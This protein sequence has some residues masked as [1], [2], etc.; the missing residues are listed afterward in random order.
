MDISFAVRLPVDS[1]SVPFVRGLCRQ[2]LEHLSVDT[3]VI[4]DV[5]LALTEACAN[6]V[7][8]AGP[9]EEYEVHVD[10]SGNLCRI[11][12]VDQGEGFDPTA[13]QVTPPGSVLERGRGMMLMQALVDRLHFEHDGEGRHKVIL[14][15]HL[16]DTP[17]P[18]R[19][20]T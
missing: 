11:S 9:H 2:A 14:E 15:K 19:L 18:L 13:V 3:P 12:V 5:V 6:V 20:L 16:F 4:E 8:H 10:I 17:P 1:K 7:D